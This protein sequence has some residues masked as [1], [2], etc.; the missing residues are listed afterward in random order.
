MLQSIHQS[1]I[2]SVKIEKNLYQLK[3][4]WKFLWNHQIL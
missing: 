3:K 2:I 4:I 1:S